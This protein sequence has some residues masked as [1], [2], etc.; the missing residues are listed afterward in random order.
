MTNCLISTVCA[1]PFNLNTDFYLLK[2]NKVCDSNIFSLYLLMMY[3][4]MV[5]F[6]PCYQNQWHEK[7][8]CTWS[9]AH[10]HTFIGIDIK[11][12]NEVCTL[13]VCSLIRM[14]I[15][16]SSIL[17][18]RLILMH[19]NAKPK[20]TAFRFGLGGDECIIIIATKWMIEIIIY[21]SS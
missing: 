1:I 2:M 15:F 20:R 5:S 4:M 10:T 17:L 16:I 19:G 14:P 3:S 7:C 11:Y 9:R 6:F 8:K 12:Y 21:N 18:E 13:T